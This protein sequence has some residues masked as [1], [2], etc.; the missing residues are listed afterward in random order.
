MGARMGGM[1]IN[2]QTWAISFGLN[3]RGAT[4]LILAGVGLSNGLIDERIF[5]AVV[6]MAIL[7]TLVSA[8]AMSGLLRGRAAAVAGAQSISPEP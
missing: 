1:R 7:T 3:A 4:G 8:P 2:R 5:V 6:S